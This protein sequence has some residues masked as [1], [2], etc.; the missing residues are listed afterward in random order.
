M[1]CIDSILMKSVKVNLIGLYYN[2]KK[3]LKVMKCYN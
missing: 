1:C 2:L 3:K